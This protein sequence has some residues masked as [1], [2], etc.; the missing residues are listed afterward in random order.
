[1][2][3]RS[4][5]AALPI[6]YK[7]LSTFAFV[8]LLAMLLVFSLVYNQVRGLMLGN[9]EEQ[10]ENGT[11][12][13]LN[14][15]LAGARLSVRNYLRGV[16]ETDLQILERYQLR[17]QQGELSEGEARNRARSTL[18]RQSIGP[19]GYVFVLNSQGRVLVH[20]S[21]AVQG[22][23]VSAL[24]FVQEILETG[25][26]GYVEYLWRNPGEL[27]EVSKAVFV[28][29]HAAW[30]WYIC[31][32]SYQK[33]F[34]ALINPHD[35]RKGME[36]VSSSMH[37]EVYVFDG[38]GDAIIGPP[39]SGLLD[40]QNE[41]SRRVLQTFMSQRNGRIFYSWKE[42][43]DAVARTRLA[44]YRDIPDLGW[45][46]VSTVPVDEYYR[47]LHLLQLS[48]LASFI[49]TM[50]LVVPFSFWIGSY[51][52]RPLQNL[53]GKF[54]RGAKGDLSVRTD[55]GPPDE[56]GRLSAFFNEFMIRL[57]AYSNALRESEERYRTAMDSTPDPLL[58]YDM[59]HRVSYCNPA[60]SRVFGWSQEDVLGQQPDF[61]PQEYAQEADHFM[62]AVEQGTTVHGLETA[63]L[64]R[65][66]ELRYVIMSGA[67]YGGRDAAPMGMVVS[68]QDVTAHRLAEEA[69]KRSDDEI[70]EQLE[71]QVS[72]RTKALE[73]V[74]EELRLAKEAAEAATETKSEFLANVSHEIR[75][76]LNG[77]IGATDLA[78]WE[79]LT[80]KLQRYIDIVHTSAESLLAIIEGI[81]DFSKIEAGRLELEE[82]EFSLTL[83][84]NEIRGLFSPRATQKGIELLFHIR[85]QVPIRLIGDSLRLKQVLINLV[86][87]AL[88]FTESGGSIVV[89]CS[90]KDA[91]ANDRLLFDFSVTDTGIGISDAQQERLFNPFTQADASTTRKY[92]GTGLGLSISKRL[93]ALMGGEIGV[94][95]TPGEGSTF[96]FSVALKKHPDAGKMQEFP[97]LQGKRVLVVDD[98]VYGRSVASSQLQALGVAYTALADGET[99]LETLQAAMQG[100]I[101]M[102]DA[103]MIDWRMPEMDGFELA[104]RICDELKLKLPTVLITAF[105]EDKGLQE[106]NMLHID[107]LLGKPYLQETLGQALEQLF[108]DRKDAPTGEESIEQD[109]QGLALAGMRVLIAED[110][111]TNQ[112]IAA[113]IL[114][115]AGMQTVVA[116]NGLEAWE[117][118]EEM[119]REGCDAVLVDLRMPEMNGFEFAQKL[120]RTPQFAGLPLIA[121]TAR[122][123][124]ETETQ[125]RVSGMDGIVS[126]PYDRKTLIQALVKYCSGL[127]VA[128]SEK[129]VNK[130]RRLDTSTV[131]GVA[132]DLATVSGL[133][134]AASMQRLGLDNDGFRRILGKFRH[135]NQNTAVRLREVWGRGDYSTLSSEAHSLKGSA[136][137]IGAV[138]LQAAAQELDDA[139]KKKITS[140]E[141]VAAVER[142]LGSL[143]RS[144]EGVREPERPRQ[145]KVEKTD[146]AAMRA[147]ISSMRTALAT[148]QPVAVSS[149]LEK[150]HSYFDQA[151][152]N[153]LQSLAEEYEYELA[154]DA[155]G[156]LESSLEPA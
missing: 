150:M 100:E 152:L 29:Y 105:A 16:A 77:I 9:M 92:G 91:A 38:N 85:P 138:A 118:L 110:N 125:C 54:E 56:L 130:P 83:L 147:A 111:P 27:H 113:A 79:N 148:A 140:A 112:E 144:L 139:S 120:R 137:S 131:F 107:G 145:R 4:K 2:G 154:L 126:K 128:T 42:G 55:P 72:E 41:D 153:D 102:F 71:Q 151:E 88:K 13:I 11:S 22:Q 76:P 32:S 124:S 59:S 57:E 108:G 97:N 116:D 155:L 104:R 19:S 93:V 52:T 65:N 58:V 90:I 51:I 122:T 115:S 66:G 31:S 109:A 18:L 49:L 127:T 63:R 156:V 70:R 3:L 1:M 78:R 143:L 69:L 23:D 94:V 103:L 50:L 30:D 43:D 15:V 146:E 98:S 86:G 14:M 96:T 134:A 81:L 132:P 117:R 149:A 26:G 47:P 60:F 136:G 84:L 135:A 12:S 99:A 68:M 20:P 73:A 8:V 123:G 121:V 34:R 36:S 24:P 40:P 48:V 101:P 45:V 67:L 82:G 129:K 5:I 53:I 114:E 119:G 74:N 17:V 75:T 80:P 10:L 21:S 89:G 6:R 7:L 61:V 46:V 28:E 64:T 37:G 25:S 44:V 62:H 87:N 33:E 35:F 141:H 95:S 142:E 133:D 106:A 39:D